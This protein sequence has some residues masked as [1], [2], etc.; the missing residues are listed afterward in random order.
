ME[1]NSSSYNGYESSFT[2]PSSPLLV[3]K[4]KQMSTPVTVPIQAEEEDDLDLAPLESTEQTVLSH[5]EL[6]FEENEKEQASVI[7]DSVRKINQAFEN[8]NCKTI[9]AT[10]LKAE[11]SLK[12]I[13]ESLCQQRQENAEALLQ[14]C[15]HKKRSLELN[16]RIQAMENRLQALIS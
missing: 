9:M 15:H 14:L 6:Y 2:A 13:R 16:S 11:S 8:A 3:K 5:K 1:S 12:A 7:A 4:P 10:A